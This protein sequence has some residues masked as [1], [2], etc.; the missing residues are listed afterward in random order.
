[1]G[2]SF[3][4]CDFLKTSLEEKYIYFQTDISQSNPEFLESY[5]LK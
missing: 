5:Q 3:E 2:W 1:M 4:D